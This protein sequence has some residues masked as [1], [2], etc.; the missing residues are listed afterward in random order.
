MLKEASS[1]RIRLVTFMA[2]V[3]MPL[4]G[5]VTDIYLPSFPAMAKSLLVHERDIQLTL[6]SYL[7]SYGISQLF[8]GNILDSIGRYRP[9]L[10]ALTFLILSSLL[11]THTHSVLLICL[12]RVVQG[13]AI[14]ILV[15]ATR[16]LFVDLYAGDR[17]KNYLSYFTIVWS[18]GPILAPFLG[19]YL[20]KLFDWQAN[21]YFLAF[22][23]AALLLFEVLYSGESI[24]E[25][26]KI[27]LRDNLNLYKMMLQ[28]KLFILGILVLGFSYSIVMLFN[29]TGPFIIENTFHFSSVTI[30]YCTLILGF[31][32]MIGGFI[33]KKR[34]HLDFVPRV[35]VPALFQAS[36]IVALI[37]VSMFQQNLYIMVGFAF[38][39]HIISG[40]LFTSFFTNSMLFFPKHAGTAGGLM[41]GMVYI[42]TSLSNFIVAISG[43]V[44]TQNG[45]AWRYFIFSMLLTLIIMYMW[46]LQKNNR[47][48][49]SSS[50]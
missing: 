28:N 8:I 29:M 25:K 40:V 43:K 1:Q 44:T 33:T 20:E 5:F 37:V 13:V 15:V 14:S 50:S 10:L 35:I 21:F 18:C 26:K 49:N 45:L 6:T 24:A 31:S 36:L 41:G 27:N 9:K 17:L 16:A 48:Q 11:I 39:I 34:M 2:F 46:N 12:L 19:G 3:S 32:W 38:F 4:S 23:A 22:Y 42:V 47:R 7:L 30:G